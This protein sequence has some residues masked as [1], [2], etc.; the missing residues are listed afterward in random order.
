MLTVTTFDLKKV[1]AHA[2][3][4][5]KLILIHAFEVLFNAC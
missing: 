5:I 4:N 2:K 1:F 3:I